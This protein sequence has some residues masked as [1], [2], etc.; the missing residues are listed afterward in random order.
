MNGSVIVKTLGPILSSF[1]KT[2]YI[3]TPDLSINLVQKTNISDTDTALAEKQVK[4]M[5]MSILNYYENHRAF[6]THTFTTIL[7]NSAN[8]ANDEK[9]AQDREISH[10]EIDKAVHGTAHFLWQYYGYVLL[11]VQMLANYQDDQFFFPM[12]IAARKT[13]FYSSL[14]MW[15]G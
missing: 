6:Y 3:D 8:I 13:S 15:V 14:E 5:Q 11:W 2:P 12:A 10:F 1:F 7:Q 9:I 4:F